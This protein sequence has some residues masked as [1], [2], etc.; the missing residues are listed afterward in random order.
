MNYYIVDYENVKSAG[1][2][3]VEKLTEN[4][5]V[6][7]FYSVNADTMTFDMHHNI[8]AS[9]A[10]IE[11]QK[12]TV[13]GKNALD[14]QLSSYLGYLIC[15]TLN[16]KETMDICNYYI[17][18]NDTGYTFL[19]HYWKDKGYNV[20]LVRN[21]LGNNNQEIN[22]IQPPKN[23]TTNSNKNELEKKLEL[24]LPDKSDAPAVAKIINQY[25]TKQGVN[26][27]LTK[28]FPPNKVG[29]I[30]KAIKSLIA[31]KKGR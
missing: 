18:S 19:C 25:K 22:T 31:S 11:F 6:I 27:G 2:D 15:D 13:G 24:I 21:M 4:D 10:S 20:K 16:N 12:V 8:N 28:K 7:A 29:P 30:H 17:V 26:N 3:G 9:K 5:I 1:F 14:F 23:S